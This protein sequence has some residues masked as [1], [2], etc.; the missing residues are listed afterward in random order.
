MKKGKSLKDSRGNTS[1]TIR[2]TVSKKDNTTLSRNQAFV[3][4]VVPVVAS[5]FFAFALHVYYVVQ[6]AL[7]H[8]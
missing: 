1:K 3:R 6:D 7:E 5:A 4:R 2:A 8:A